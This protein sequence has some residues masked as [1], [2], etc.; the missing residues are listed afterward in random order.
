MGLRLAP[1]E[2]FL[3]QYVHSTPLAATVADL[4]GE[5]RAALAREVVAGWEPFV[6][7]N[8]LVLVLPVVVATARAI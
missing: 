1:P 5:G 3:W 7:Q 8:V 6:E 4:D 2:E